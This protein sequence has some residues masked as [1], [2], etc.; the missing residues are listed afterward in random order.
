M[1]ALFGKVT[2]LQ[3]KMPGLNNLLIDGPLGYHVRDGGH[4]LTALDWKLYLDHAD[5]LFFRMETKK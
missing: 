1:W 4:D 5:R 3:D 2:A